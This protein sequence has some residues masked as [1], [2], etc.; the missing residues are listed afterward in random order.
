MKN[1][2]FFVLVFLFAIG[3]NTEGCGTKSYNQRTGAPIGKGADLKPLV[4]KRGSLLVS[5]CYLIDV[6]EIAELLGIEANVI[7][8][9]DST[10]RN[11]NPSHASCF[12]RFEDPR[13]VSAGILLQIMKSPEEGEEYAAFAEKMIESKIVLGEQSIDGPPEKFQPL[14]GFGEGGAYSMAAGRYFW[15]VGNQLVFSIAFNTA[16]TPQQQFDIAQQLATKMTL[17]YLNN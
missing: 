4:K 11:N 2:H 3:C 15:N 10:P 13:V 14:A 17:N 9:K 5:T 12:F 1:F 7:Q 8:I 16:H 6:Q